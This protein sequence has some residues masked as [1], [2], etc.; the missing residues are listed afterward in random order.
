MQVFYPRVLTQVLRKLA[1]KW[2]KVCFSP[3][4]L[5]IAI[6]NA[7]RW[8]FVSRKNN[9]NSVFD[10]HSSSSLN[11]SSLKSRVFI[12]N[13]ERGHSNNPISWSALTSKTIV[14]YR[15]KGPNIFEPV[16]VSFFLLRTRLEQH[17]ILVNLKSCGLVS[18]LPLVQRDLGSRKSAATS[19]N[20]ATSWT[21]T[22]TC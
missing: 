11:S 17:L 3:Y 1:V 12:K 16:V 22:L 19:P 9:L 4:N 21:Q 6:F 2:R 10:D 14:F 15:S 5:E 18:E 13:C 20:L 8:S 7:S